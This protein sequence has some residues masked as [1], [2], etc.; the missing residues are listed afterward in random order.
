MRNSAILFSVFFL[1]LNFLKAQTIEFIPHKVKPKLSFE[2]LQ[3]KNEQDLG[4]LG[5]GTD[6]YIFEKIPNLYVTLNSYS[7][8]TG[9]R[10]GLISIGTGL[11]YTQQ[12]FN[13]DFYLDGGVFV[14]GGG[15][16]NAPDGGGL[17]T[18]EHLNL[19]YRFSG[20]EIFA[21][22]SRL[23]FPTGDMGSNNFN[24]GL[25]LASVFDTAYDSES[26]LDSF[27]QNP[28]TSKSKT[29]INF[30]GTAYVHF[31]DGPF[32]TT[33][34]GKNIQLLGVE[35]DK[36]FNKKFYAALKLS[37]AVTGGVDGYMNLLVGLGFQQNLWSK[38]VSAEV[39]LLG[40]PSGGGGIASGGGATFQGVGGLS[41]HVGNGYE[42]NGSVGQV[43]APEGNFSGTFVE[44]GLAKNFNFIYP[45]GHLKTLYKLELDEK[46]EGFGFRVV[47][48][49]YI[50]P[51]R[52]D[53]NNNYYDDYFNLIGFKIS[54]DISPKFNAL[55][56]TYWAYQGSYGAY[57]EG[58]LGVQ[59]HFPVFKTWEINFDLMGG[60]AGGGG[61]DLGSGLAFQFGGGIS[62]SFGRNWNVLANA[63]TMQG[64]KGNF[65][66]IYF[67]FGVGYNFMQLIK[68]N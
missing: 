6:F 5:I 26:D 28:V 45:V 53:K 54:K 42:L 63:G 49:L 23:D 68:K 32:E 64:F 44:F 38:N 22:Y 18:R 34:K 4:M 30:I 21:G 58:W 1:F 47:N 41:V 2:I 65:K 8:V 9:N 20:A 25:A 55:G 43:Y 52:L 11:G 56:S 14:G 24:F 13:S 61:I 60:A 62:K 16:A 59:Y 29:R 33:G 27:H 50:P 12:L 3:M 67:D 39:K 15:G 17:I 36:F 31:S 35:I 51:N 48:R 19:T 37:G 10:P 66:P 57:A 7:A 40:G 46:L